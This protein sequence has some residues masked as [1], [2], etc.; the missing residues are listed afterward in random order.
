MATRKSKPQEVIILWKEKHGTAAHTVMTLAYYS[1][2]GKVRVYHRD[3]YDGRL[4]LGRGT[5]LPYFA[6]GMLALLHMERHLGLD[7]MCQV[8]VRTAG[9]LGFKRWELAAVA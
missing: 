9:A 6:D 5:P 8:S 1:G 3:Q 7:G 4:D 2:Q